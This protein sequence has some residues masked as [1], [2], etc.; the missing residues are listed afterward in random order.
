[1]AFPFNFPLRPP[2]KQRAPPSTDRR[3]EVRY[4]AGR[5]ELLSWLQLSAR[6]ANGPLV[7]REAATA[8]AA[9][10]AETGRRRNGEENARG[11]GVLPKL[12]KSKFLRTFF[13][14]FSLVPLHLLA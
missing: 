6:L 11:R 14:C 12:L 1:M 2:K 13:F 7:R 3:P 5:V 4:A 9:T 8:A 10:E